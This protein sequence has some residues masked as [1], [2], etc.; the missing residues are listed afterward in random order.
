[1]FDG[2]HV[3]RVPR[4]AGGVVDAADVTD[5]GRDF[6][7]TEIGASESDT[8]IR[9][10]G[11]EGKR[12]LL[13]RMKTNSGAGD[14]PTKRPLC[15]HLVLETVVRSRPVPKQAECPYTALGIAPPKVLHRNELALML[16]RGAIGR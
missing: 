11:L 14:W 6:K 16:R 13:A 4:Q 8:E 10:R 7:A 12:H 5:V 1:M 2:V 9:W 15:V 3:D